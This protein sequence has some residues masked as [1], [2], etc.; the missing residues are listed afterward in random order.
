MMMMMMIT[1]VIV[2]VFLMIEL[3]RTVSQ[4][5]QKDFSYCISFNQQIL[6]DMLE[7]S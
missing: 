2:K 5:I 4:T 3:L 7:E 6:K 1:E